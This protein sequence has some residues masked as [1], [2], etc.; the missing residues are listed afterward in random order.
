M[1]DNDN[2]QA[3][4]LAKAQTLSTLIALLPDGLQGIREL[5][6]KGSDF[7]YPCVRIELESQTDST[8]TNVSCP[9]NIDF[10]FYI[11]SET[12]SSKQA[13]SLAGK[14]VSGL[15]GIGFAQNNIKFVHIKILESIPAIAQDERTWRA[16]VRCRSTIH[17]I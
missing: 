1:L 11:F 7:A 6:W 15:R 2:I 3:A 4:I 8:E 13:N 10:S 5:N 17:A 12:A 9:S 16:Q 14:I